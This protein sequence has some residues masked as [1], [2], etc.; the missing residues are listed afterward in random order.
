MNPELPPIIQAQLDAATL[1]QL[2]FDIEHSAELL[3]VTIKPRGSRWASATTAQ[4]NLTL[5]DAYRELSTGSAAVQLRY[6]HAGEEWWDT[7][8]PHEGGWRLTRISHTRALT[9]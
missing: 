3:G 2:L 1:G 5:A 7:L 8:T 6:L 9:T 4:A